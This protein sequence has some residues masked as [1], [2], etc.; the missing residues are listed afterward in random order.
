MFGGLYGDL[1]PP[2][3]TRE[4]EQTKS[5]GEEDKKPGS[6]WS[7]NKMFLAPRKSGAGKELPC[8]ARF[9]KQ[10][11]KECFKVDEESRKP[12]VQWNGI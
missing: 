3:A 4:G 11:K 9:V 8:S 12:S 2:S 6:G 7:A 5:N 1:P 10:L